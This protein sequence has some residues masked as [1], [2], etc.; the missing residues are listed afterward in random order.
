MIILILRIRLDR[1]RRQRNQR[2]RSIWARK[3]LVVVRRRK[4]EDRALKLN[5]KL[6]MRVRK[7]SLVM[8]NIVYL[9]ILI[10]FSNKKQN[11]TENVVMI[12][13]S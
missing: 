3:G 11:C 2:R 5:T 1:V 6:K 13:H 10:F 9:G 7:K 4:V 8:L 12:N